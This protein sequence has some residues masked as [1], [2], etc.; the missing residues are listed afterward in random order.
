[1]ANEPAAGWYPD[2]KDPSQ[3]RYWDGS[4]WTEHTQASG[5]SEQEPQA[6][7]AEP[8]AAEP[9]A[10]EPVAPA[11]P[12][13]Q[14]AAAATPQAPQAPQAPRGPAAP[15]APGVPPGGFQP[16]PAGGAAWTGPPLAEWVPRFLAFLIDFLIIWAVGIVGRILA[17]ATGSSGIAL[18][19][20]LV[21]LVIAFLYFPLTMMREGPQNGQSIG[22]GVTG[23]RVLR[24]DGRPVTFGFA[25]LRQFVV[26]YLLFGIV[27]CCGLGLILDGLWPLWDDKNEALHDKIVKTHVIQA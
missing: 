5:G 10:A 6:A 27:A 18:L 25:V 12:A 20:G 23:I 21:S 22:M 9:A 17:F 19:L 3:R 1:M 14:P 26:I 13:A 24:D 2:P 4:A 15:Q 8:A 7:A 11:A 16:V